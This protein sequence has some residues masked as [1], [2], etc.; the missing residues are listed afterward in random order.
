MSKIFLVGKKRV[1]VPN[2]FV[3]WTFEKWR[4]VVTPRT[5]ETDPNSWRHDWTPKTWYGLTMEC[6]EDHDA[7][8]VP[9]YGDQDLNEEFLSSFFKHC[10]AENDRPVCEVVQ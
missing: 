9:I 7:M 10:V 2:P 3:A 1:S 8:G 5:D 4:L 6:V